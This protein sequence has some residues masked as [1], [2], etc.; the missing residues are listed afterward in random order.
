MSAITIEQTPEQAKL[1]IELH[2]HA[3]LRSIRVARSRISNRLA[4][5]STASKIALEFAFRSKRIE[6]PSDVIRL[7][8]LFQL[9]GREST[10][11]ESQ[12][13]KPE[14]A[15]MVNC[16]Y[17]VEYSV[18][19]SFDAT[20]AHVD[21]FKD[22]NA[23]FNCWPYFREYLQSSLVRMNLPVFTAPFLRLQAKQGKKSVVTKR[24]K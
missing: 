6:A 10:D 13:A 1:A 24:K 12:A 4:D 17:A 16:V 5:L 2:H 18:D 23:I 19:A 8:C 9:T 7:E 14:A 20:P 11:A 21:A 22:G 15:I 3:A